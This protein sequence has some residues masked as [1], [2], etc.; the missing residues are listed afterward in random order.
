VYTTSSK[1]QLIENL[2]LL[3]EQQKISFPP[4]QELVDELEIFSFDITA[5]GNI[6]YGAPRGFHDDC[7]NALGLACWDYQPA[8]ID[9]AS[10]YLPPQNL[11]T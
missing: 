3:I 5:S 10:V 11:Y 1:K 4:I 6:K 9:R 7:V 2:I 8:E